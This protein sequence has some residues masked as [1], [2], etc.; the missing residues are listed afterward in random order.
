MPHP[1]AADVKKTA[2]HPAPPAPAVPGPGASV[3]APA[4][5]PPVAPSPLAATVRAMLA[6]LPRDLATAPWP[7]PA[8]YSEFLAARTAV[9]A[10]LVGE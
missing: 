8:K 9:E 6:A 3:S 10:A 7:T 2:A 4:S 5:A 1:V